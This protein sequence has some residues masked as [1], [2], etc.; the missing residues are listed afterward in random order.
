MGSKASFALGRRRVAEPGSCTMA[1]P[2]GFGRTARSRILSW[3]NP[4][5]PMSRTVPPGGLFPDNDGHLHSAM[6]GAT[7]VVA[8]GPVG[9][10]RLRRHREL[11]DTAGNDFGVDPEWPHEEPVGHVLALDLELHCLAP[12]QRD[13]VPAELEPLAGDHD[14]PT[15][16]LR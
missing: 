6:A 16:F 8:D 14:D 15:P 4:P 13:Q 2:A 7:E 12:G 9:P 11:G 3:P 5:P 1:S 10:G